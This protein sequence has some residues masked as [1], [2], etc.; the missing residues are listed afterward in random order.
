[1]LAALWCRLF[2]GHDWIRTFYR[3][4]IFLECCHCGAKTKGWEVLT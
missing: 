3:G 1:M 4:R 2:R